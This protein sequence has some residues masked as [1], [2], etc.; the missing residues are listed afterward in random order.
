[1]LP[2]QSVPE[3]SESERLAAE[4]EALG[5]YISSHPLTAVQQHLQ[6]LTTAT[7]QSLAECPSDQPVTVGGIITQRR[8]QLT[9]NG[10]RMAFLT[11]EDL[12]GTFEVIVFPEIYR[13]SVA[14]CESDAP[15][16]VW[17]KAESDTSEGRVLAQR[18]LPLEADET[19][20]GFRRLTLLVSPQLG[21]SVLLQVRDLLTASP[22]DSSV[23]LAVPFA[24]GERVV[25]RAS[26]RLNVMPSHAL[27]DALDQ[28]LGAGN[29]RV[30]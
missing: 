24:D 15:I 30:G 18:L 23:M 11:L 22:G 3:W 20:R 16:L 1:M 27:L 14:W 4:K 13:Q 29:V 19:W 12:Y 5:F 25:M 26:E 17:G 2:L 28:L 10:E 6:R 8:T 21:R 9:K 7:S